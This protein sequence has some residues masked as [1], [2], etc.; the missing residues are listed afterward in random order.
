MLTNYGKCACEINSGIAVA[1]TAFN[2]K[3]ALY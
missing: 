3:R 1:R 2:K